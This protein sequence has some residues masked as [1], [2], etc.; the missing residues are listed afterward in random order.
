MKTYS[1]DPATGCGWMVLIGIGI[2]V[3]LLTLVYLNWA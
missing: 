3:T 2:L 1:S